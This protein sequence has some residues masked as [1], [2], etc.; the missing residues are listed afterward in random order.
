MSDI[1]TKKCDQCGTIKGEGNGWWFLIWNR[2]NEFKT[3][4]HLDIA[5]VNGLP[6]DDLC[7]IPCLV[8]RI[9]QLAGEQKDVSGNGEFTGAWKGDID[10]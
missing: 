5:H 3:F 7:G 1:I 10:K 9:T 4:G 2:N 6:H 8:K